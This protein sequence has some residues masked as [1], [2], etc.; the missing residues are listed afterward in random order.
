MPVTFEEYEQEL[1][2]GQP[3]E[4]DADN[5][6]KQAFRD[7]RSVAEGDSGMELR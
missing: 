3:E 7:S 2:V 5:Q 4:T 1:A 6:E